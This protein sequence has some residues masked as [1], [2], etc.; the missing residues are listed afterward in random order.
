MRAS[1][2]ISAL[3]MITLPLSALA[4]PPANAA[5]AKPAI[6]RPLALT[7]GQFEALRQIENQPQ[8]RAVLAVH[9][10]Y[11][12]EHER[13]MDLVRASDDFW[14]AAYTFGFPGTIIA[15]L[16]CAAPL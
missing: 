8:H 15:M 13:H 9:A 12:S 10:T 7:N 11:K 16:I 5:A 4:Q 14:T 3:L 6:S 2:L 1:L